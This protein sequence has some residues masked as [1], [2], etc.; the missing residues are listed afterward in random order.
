MGNFHVI[1][2]SGHCGS[3]WLARVLGAGT[4]IKWYHERRRAL[5]GKWLEACRLGPDHER[6]DEYW[7]RI[8]GELRHTD[9]GD[10]NSWMP[11]LLIEAN[12]IVPIKRVIYL[13]RNPIQQL[14]SLTRTSYV[15]SKDPG[16]LSPIAMTYLAVLHMSSGLNKTTWDDW[17]HWEKLCL[18]VRANDVLPDILRANGLSVDVYALE[19]LTTDPRALLE[20]APDLSLDEARAW[21]KRDINRKVYGD[22]SP[23]ALW[24]KWTPEQRDGFERVV[25]KPQL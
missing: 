24:L 7:K 9:V 11:I 3:L 19:T 22:R 6:F 10:S 21:Q 5:A 20:L 12:K 14:H 23:Q 2:G 17:T 18:L 25:G 15:W 13:V 4:D 8:K 1:A 16:Q